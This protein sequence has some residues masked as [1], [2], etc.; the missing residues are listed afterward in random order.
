MQI[1]D[2]TLMALADGELDPL[3][4]EAVRAAVASDSGLQQRLHRFQETRRLLAGMKVIAA[5]EDPLAAHIRATAAP[6]APAGT[7]T[8][9]NLNRRP[10]LAAACAAILALGLG[11]WWLDQPQ[12]GF[13]AAE[14][15]ALESLPSG[16]AQRF[17][18]DSDLV[19]IA[20]FLTVGGEFCREYEI[21]Q[22][23]TVRVVLA[24]ESEDGWQ[25]RFASTSETGDDSYRPA[26]GAETIDDALEEIGAAGV[27]TTAEEARRL[28]QKDV[29][30]SF[31][32]ASFSAGST[33]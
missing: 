18:D 27:M 8:P 7:A 6:K 22:P 20:S 31:G 12:D 29:S 4:A 1:D 32:E 28:D 14:I 2:E 23:R 5:E 24:C 16:E 9:A 11:W 25:Q 30:P 13:S 19:M 10:L 17:D 15:A 33:D 26:S 21:S 3:R